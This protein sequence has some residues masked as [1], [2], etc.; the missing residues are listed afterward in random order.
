MR[1]QGVRKL[2]VGIDLDLLRRQRGVQKMISAETQHAVDE[3]V[4]NV[5]GYVTE[6][7]DIEAAN[8]RRL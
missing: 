7:H 3:L 8:L 4:L 2:Y 6:R 1:P 5:L